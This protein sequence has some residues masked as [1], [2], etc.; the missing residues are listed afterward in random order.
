MWFGETLDRQ[1]ERRKAFR[2]TAGIPQRRSAVAGEGAFRIEIGFLEIQADRHIEH[3]AHACIAIGRALGLWDI[4]HYRR[5]WIEHPLAFQYAGEN[6]SHRLA[7]GEDDVALA[8]RHVRR[9]PVA[10]RPAAL[11]D[12]QAV[13]V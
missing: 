3:V 4:L 12:R 7:D 1:Q 10:D 2:T 8:K 9:R 11:Q 6:G 5:L 13:G